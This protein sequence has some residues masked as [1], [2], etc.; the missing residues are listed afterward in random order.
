MCVCVNLFCCLAPPTIHKRPGIF[1]LLQLVFGDKNGG[2]SPQPTAVTIKEL[3]RLTTRRLSNGSPPAD[4]WEVR[5]PFCANKSAAHWT[6][7]VQRCLRYA[8]LLRFTQATA[9]RKRTMNAP[10]LSRSMG[11]VSARRFRNSRHAVS[12]GFI[13]WEHLG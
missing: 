3:K 4:Q 10:R 6:W 8:C 2:T 7:Q 13:S 12:I 5:A 11:C 1:K 9:A